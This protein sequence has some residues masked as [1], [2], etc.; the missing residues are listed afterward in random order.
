[1]SYFEDLSRFRYLFGGSSAILNVGWLEAPRPF[2]RGAVA[3]EDVAR[4][5]RLLVHGFQPAFAKGWH[6][7]SLCGQTSTD[8]PIE[9]EIGGQRRVLG[10]DIL[11]VPAGKRMFA[12]PSLVIHY[13]EAHGYRPP[14]PFLEALRHADP[15][16][17]AYRADCERIWNSGLV[18][19]LSRVFQRRL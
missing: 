18:G 2:P 19:L 8:P 17:P 16:S 7:C 14:E 6:G 1:M 13:I 15:T 9:R 4:L 3:P 5:E 10:A 11:F 12:A